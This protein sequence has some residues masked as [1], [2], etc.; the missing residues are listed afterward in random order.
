M[1]D[2]FSFSFVWRALA[3]IVIAAVVS[4]VVGTF[5]VLRGFSTLSA[6]I[7]HS[8]FAGA[9]IATIY[10]VNPLLGALTLS[11]G[12]SGLT[13]Y[14]SSSNERKADVVVGMMFGFSTALAVLFLSIASTYT[15]AAWSF[16]IGDVL[17]VSWIDLYTLI[18]VAIT[19]LSIVIISY[20]EFK[21][22]TFDPEAAEA[23]G[24]RVSLYHYVMV[25][26][27]ALFSIVAIKVVG[28]ILAIVL[29]IA[30]AASAYEFSHNLERMIAISLIISLIAGLSGFFLSLIFNVASS[31]LIGIVVS[32]AYLLALIASPK[33][34]RCKE[35]AR[36]RRIVKEM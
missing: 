12:F 33:R 24:L 9:A 32:A 6:A 5:T 29:L 18:A 25:F 36:F 22:I 4:S 1:L 35:M 7:T 15:A 26:L 10:G 30:P 14:V 13:A 20:K 28:V 21:F 8:S 16:I 23:M 3:S 17:G 31:A 34:R 2:V 19:T 11:L 27:I